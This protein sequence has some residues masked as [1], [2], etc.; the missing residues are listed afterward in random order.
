MYLQVAVHH[1][2]GGT[3]LIWSRNVLSLYVKATCKVQ[4]PKPILYT[5]KMHTHHVSGLG[6][7]KERWKVL[8][9]TFRAEYLPAPFPPL[10]ESSTQPQEHPRLGEDLTDSATRSLPCTGILGGGYWRYQWPQVEKVEGL[11]LVQTLSISSS[12]P[13]AHLAQPIESP[14]LE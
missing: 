6:H 10:A 1:L 14:C 5:H 12:S 9:R 11:D 8:S 13:P 3:A 2:V 4:V 7:L